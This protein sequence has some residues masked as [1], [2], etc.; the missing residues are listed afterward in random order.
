VYVDSIQRHYDV[1]LG[2]GFALLNRFFPS[3]GRLDISSRMRNFHNYLY[4]ALAFMPLA[5]LVGLI[6]RQL[7]TNVLLRILIAS[8]GIAAPPILLEAL[9]RYD[10]GT[11]FNRENLLV[12]LAIM[13]GTTVL[14]LLYHWLNQHP[15]SQPHL[16]NKL[17]NTSATLTCP[18]CG[19]GN[20]QIFFE[21]TNIP[22]HCNVLLATAS[23]AL[24]VPRGDM[25]LGFCAACGHLYNYAFSPDLMTYTQAYE[26]SLH[27]SPRFER[28]AEELATR[29][30]ER[31][32]LHGKPS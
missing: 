24:N 4:D 28:Y 18:V 9:L 23:E 8:V 6:V 16:I 22:V 21:M 19:F 26:N 25:Q 15:F 12:G 10:I 32:N 29:L 31:Y 2:P 11:E 13:F 3:S 1:N 14:T 7:R 27:F 30:I 20:V 17:M 5:Y